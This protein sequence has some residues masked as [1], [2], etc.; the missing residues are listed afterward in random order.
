M[1][2]QWVKGTDAF[3]PQVQLMRRGVIRTIEETF[4]RFGF[5][6]VETPALNQLEL[7]ASKYAGGA[8]I[9]KEMLQ[10][11]DLGGR[12]LGLRYDLTVPFAIL[13]GLSQGSDFPMPFK[14][15][16][17]GKVFRDGP[18]KRGRRVEF[19]QCDADV[20]GIRSVQADAELIAMADQVFAELGLAAH[21]ELNHRKLL[22]ALIR[23]AGVAEER[24]GPT[25]LAVDK[26]QK[27][28]RE[29]VAAELA[30]KGVAAEC[31]ARLFDLLD[32]EG[33]TEEALEK[34]SALANSEAAA[35]AVAE[36]R[37]LLDAL[38]AMSVKMPV[39]LT[40]G[41][42]RGL[43]IYTGP[44]FEFFLDDQSVVSSSI[45][46]GGRYD[47]IIGQFLYPDKPARHEDFP[48]T[49]ISFGLEPITIA[50]LE[51]QKAAETTTPQSDVQ[52][53]VCPLETLNESLAIA[54]RLRRAGIRTEVAYYHR[55]LKKAL[56]YA[57]RLNI[58]FAMIIGG[59]E[60]AR[61]VVNLRDMRC[62]E[63]LELTLEQA[64]ARI[65]ESDC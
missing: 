32:I 1:E 65:R 13:I 33:S 36:L 9:L 45:G 6:P 8:E 24:I 26:L 29:G 31:A 14:R 61:G 28:G 20:T 34:I 18:V 60:V 62:S 51:Q 30:E 37:Q 56:N 52:V 19:T 10:L 55:K 25:I 46:G 43:E 35:E 50:L 48:A 40:L 59:D 64:I 22:S 15:Y 63:Q 7:L 38:E 4:A 39:K 23:E 49:G 12:E 5:N 2:L 41:L 27:I 21:T 47:R 16:E 17:I 44:V 57:N 3:L 11:T 42:A 58:P 53:V 54:D